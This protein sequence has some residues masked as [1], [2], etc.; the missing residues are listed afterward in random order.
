ME[1]D[2]IVLME[3]IYCLNKPR[4]EQ[5]KNG[6]VFTMAFPKTVLNV[7]PVAFLCCKS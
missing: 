5:E 7:F 3:G 2:G 6:T 4:E 1:W